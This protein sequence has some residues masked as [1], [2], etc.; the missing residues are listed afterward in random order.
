VAAKRR[1]AEGHELTAPRLVRFS[2]SGV[3]DA[4]SNEDCF[5]FQ[6]RILAFDFQKDCVRPRR[7]FTELGGLTCGVEKL[8]P[9]DSQGQ[10]PPHNAVVD[11]PLSQVAHVA[12]LC[13]Q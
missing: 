6:K 11:P 9:D 4:L 10:F 5:E 3:R 12:V 2:D 1:K 8:R 7:E 13:G